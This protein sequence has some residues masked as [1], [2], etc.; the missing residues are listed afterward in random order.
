MFINFDYDSNSERFTTSIDI[1]GENFRTFNINISG[2][3]VVVRKNLIKSFN[4]IDLVV[5]STFDDE[6]SFLIKELIET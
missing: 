2:F 3:L 4:N 1:Y 6:I 5:T